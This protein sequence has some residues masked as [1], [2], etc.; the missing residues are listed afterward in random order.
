MCPSLISTSRAKVRRSPGRSKFRCSWKRT[1]T[2]PSNTAQEVAEYVVWPRRGQARTLVV[3]ASRFEAD[4]FL[5]CQLP[6]RSFQRVQRDLWCNQPAN[7]DAVPRVSL[8]IFQGRLQQLEV[9]LSELLIQL[10]VDLVVAAGFSGSLTADLAFGALVIGL[11][12]SDIPPP[13]FAQQTAVS[14]GISSVRT[15]STPRVVESERLRQ[16]L[17]EQ[18]GADIVDVESERI[19]RVCRSHGVFCLRM[20][21]ISDQNSSDLPVPSAVMW[22]AET[23]S[24]RIGRLTRHLVGH[25]CRLWTFLRAVTRWRRA[26]DHLASALNLLLRLPEQEEI[27]PWQNPD[28]RDS[29]T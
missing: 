15:V 14:L 6:D 1:S 21:V 25:P 29:Q 5:R 18:S 11:G 17:R 22:N 13:D 7:T 28:Q 12:P 4:P 24:P 9:R 26:A 23:A 27:S 2:R 16:E 20:R 19:A 3:F 10:K 8:F